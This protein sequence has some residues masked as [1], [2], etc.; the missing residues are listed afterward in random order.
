M[1]KNPFAIK[2]H[3]RISDN[4]SANTFNNLSVKNSHTQRRPDISKNKT[5]PIIEA[6]SDAIRTAA[7]AISFEILAKKSYEG[8]DRLVKVS[9]DVLIIS[10]IIT[11]AIENSN[12]MYSTF[13]K[14]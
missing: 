2:I 11:S 7:A 10:A 8:D 14:R 5:T 6:K 13:V 1:G 12:N 3:D 9:I 4:I